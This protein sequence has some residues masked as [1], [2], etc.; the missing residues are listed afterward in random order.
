MLRFYSKVMTLKQRSV[1]KVSFTFSAY[2]IRLFLP[3]SYC[4]FM[5]H[6]IFNSIVL[7]LEVSFEKSWKGTQMPKDSCFGT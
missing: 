1:F 7:E 5:A 6:S 2:E 3:I 4:I